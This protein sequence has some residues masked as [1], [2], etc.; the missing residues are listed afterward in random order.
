MFASL[1][2]VLNEFTSQGEGETA[3]AVSNPRF[4]RN[5]APRPLSFP[6]KRG[7]LKRKST[8]GVTPMKPY[9]N[10][11]PQKSTN[12]DFRAP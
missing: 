4:R 1:M 11:P 3:L 8:G 9:L 2:G 5:C 7:A 10:A 6:K 12:I